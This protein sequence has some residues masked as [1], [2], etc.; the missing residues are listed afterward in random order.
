[1]KPIN[2]SAEKKIEKI[3]QMM[4]YIAR[5]FDK[6]F[7][8]TNLPL[9]ITSTIPDYAAETLSLKTAEESIVKE[10]MAFL[11]ATINDSGINK[12]EKDYVRYLLLLFAKNSS[13]EH[14][15]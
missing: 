8:L 7:G 12:L 3:I 13:S 6:K 2:L 11:V 15:S 14:L 4:N 1:M 5:A 10:F 9:R